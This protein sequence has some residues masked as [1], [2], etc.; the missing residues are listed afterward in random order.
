MRYFPPVRPG[1][2]PPNCACQTRPDWARISDDEP[3]TWPVQESGEW[4]ELRLCPV[5]GRP[6]LVS[7]PDALEGGAI[8]CRPRPPPS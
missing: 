4:E 5:C 1:D 2:A 3:L 6:W 7:W 8:L